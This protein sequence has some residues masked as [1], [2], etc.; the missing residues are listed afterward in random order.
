L[1]WFDYA[2]SCSFA[3]FPGPP[4]RTRSVHNATFREK[5][6]DDRG[7]WVNC[8]P[9]TTSTPT[10]YEFLRRRLL[11]LR[12]CPGS[13]PLKPVRAKS[14]FSCSTLTASS[15]T[16]GSLFFS[17][18][19]G[20]QQSVLQNCAQHGGEGGF[21]LHSE[22]LIEAKGSHAHDGTSISLAPGRPEDRTHH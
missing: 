22:S 2:R 8:C 6:P 16:A 11:K 9:S 19:S 20:T 13:S 10:G 1:C 7:N 17:A 14:N 4:G 15:P 3:E 12:R 5:P 21:C 18:L